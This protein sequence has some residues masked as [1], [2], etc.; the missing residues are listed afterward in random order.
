MLHTKAI[1]NILS[2]LLL[3][4]SLSLVIPAIISLAYAEDD[5]L[6]FV[7]TIIFSCLGTKKSCW[8]CDI[9]FTG[10]K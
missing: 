7:I 10:I 9:K 6:S 8:I 5:F 4:L 2:A 3:F 1:I